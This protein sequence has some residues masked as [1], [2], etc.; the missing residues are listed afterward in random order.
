MNDSAILDIDIIAK[1]NRIY[2]TSN[3]SIKPDR[4]IFA[5]G[6]IANDRGVFR[7]PTS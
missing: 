3:N 7:Q 6:N 1:T 2:I 5:H 4:T